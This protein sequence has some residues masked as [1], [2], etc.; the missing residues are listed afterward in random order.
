M[1]NIIRSNQNIIQD[2]LFK[3][4][5]DCFQNYRSQNFKML[6][7]WD[8]HIF[9][10]LSSSFY[11]M[12]WLTM[13]INRCSC[14]QNFVSRSVKKES[15]M[16]RATRLGWASLS[17]EMHDT[18]EIFCQLWCASY[19]QCSNLLFAA[20]S[21]SGELSKDGHPPSS[22]LETIKWNVHRVKHRQRPLT[23][24]NFGMAGIKIFWLKD[25]SYPVVKHA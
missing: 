19:L 24:N 5:K 11:E 12:F 3:C 9:K 10:L 14:T 6:K 21:E 23:S 8:R 18:P 17:N 2:I 1:Q 13:L 15:A 25:P 4:S 16:L 20:C 22:C 7:I